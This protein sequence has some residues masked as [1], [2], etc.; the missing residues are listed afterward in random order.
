MSNP[1]LNPPIRLAT[2]YCLVCGAKIGHVSPTDFHKH[3]HL[4]G[5]EFGYTTPRKTGVDTP[6]TIRKHLS[7]KPVVRD[8]ERFY[9]AREL[10]NEIG[11][12]PWDPSKAFIDNRDDGLSTTNLAAVSMT[13]NKDQNPQ[14]AIGYPMHM[15]CWTMTRVIIGQVNEQPDNLRV[16]CQILWEEIKDFETIMNRGNPSINPFSSRHG[17]REYRVNFFHI[18]QLVKDPLRISFFKQVLD[19]SRRL[20][21]LRERRQPNSGNSFRLKSLPP[22]ILELILEKLSSE[23]MKCLMLAYGDAV[24]IYH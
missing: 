19:S 1:D 23:E 13:Q 15:H 14:D 6:W 4:G 5:Y 9:C 8:N 7:T 24:P 2:Q 22:E 11:H 17:Y 10:E 16:L 20:G 21:S 12:I 18:E 3:T